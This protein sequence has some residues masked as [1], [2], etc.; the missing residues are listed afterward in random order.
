MA[1]AVGVGVALA[2]VLGEQQ[3]DAFAL[4]RCRLVR[5]V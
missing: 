1:R 5:Q 3:P 4:G 2:G